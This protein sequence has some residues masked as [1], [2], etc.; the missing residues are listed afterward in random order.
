MEES[1]ISPLLMKYLTFIIID[2]NTPLEVK[3]FFNIV[4]NQIVKN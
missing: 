4:I 3:E 2:H 1:K